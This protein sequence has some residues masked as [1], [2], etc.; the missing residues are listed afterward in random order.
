MPDGIIPKIAQPNS[1]VVLEKDPGPLS[2]T[3]TPTCG[4]ASR[5]VTFTASVPELPLKAP[6]AGVSRLT[7]RTG[8]LALAGEFTVEVSFMY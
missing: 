6:G 3:V 2:C 8:R 5:F 1:L 4:E 7:S